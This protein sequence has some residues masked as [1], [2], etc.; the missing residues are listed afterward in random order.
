M[1]VGRHVQA[2]RITGVG[3]MTRPLIRPIPVS[4]PVGVL[5]LV[6]GWVLVVVGAMWGLS[7]G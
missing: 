4:D 6:A 3:S 1:G 5:G 7:N 2:H